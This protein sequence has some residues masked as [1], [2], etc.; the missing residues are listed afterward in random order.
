MLYIQIMIC[1]C[2]KKFDK[3]SIWKLISQCH[4]F[5]KYICISLLWF[6][7]FV[8]EGSKYIC[9]CTCYIVCVSCTAQCINYHYTCLVQACDVSVSLLTHCLLLNRYKHI[10]WKT[11]PTEYMTAITFFSESLYTD[12]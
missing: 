8:G 5:S 1:F 9:S 10:K 4:N 2:L 3:I 6:V 11:P 12:K 7:V